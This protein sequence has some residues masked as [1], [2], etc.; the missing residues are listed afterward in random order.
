MGHKLSSDY[1][2]RP[3]TREDI[4]QV[5][6]IERDVF[7]KRWHGTNFSRELNS[8]TTEFV[9]CVHR[10]R[11]APPV[12]STPKRSFL[13][14]LKGKAPVYDPNNAPE[15]I[16][17]FVGLW[18]TSG[19]G[20]II[21]IAVREHDRR[22][23]L[24][25]LLLLGAVEMTERRDAQVVTLEVRVSNVVAQSL[26]SK[27]GFAQVGTRKGYYSDN[28]EDAYVMTTPTIS[29]LQFQNFLSLKRQEFD[30]RYG[31]VTRTYL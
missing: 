30:E 20:H 27:Y 24:G 2:L 5:S 1:C 16:V 3:M 18:F 11:I 13:D 31:L 15:L 26:Y 9:V 25:E 12:E 22:K 4:S 10:G 23:G 19:E 29:S 8:L 17:G 6:S 28:R 7:D 14:V 21:S